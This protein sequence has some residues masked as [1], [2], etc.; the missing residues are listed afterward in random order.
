M[1]IPFMN[2]DQ[3]NDLIRDEV[4]ESV[5]TIFDSKNYVLGSNVSKF[6]TNYSK[7]NKTKYS[8]GVGSGLDALMISLK[9]LNISKGD[10]VII[11]SN[12]YIASWLS[13]SNVG[14]TIIPVEPDSETFNI[15]A[16][17]IENMIT[18]KT[19]LIMPVHLFGQS[20]NMDKIMSISKKYN[21]Y[22]VEDNA[23]GHL[24]KYDSKNT[25]TFGNINAT[26]FYPTKNLGAIGEAGCITTDNQNLKDFVVSYRNYGS[27]EKYINEIIGTNSRLDEIQAGILNVK[28]RYIQKWNNDR[29]IIASKYNSF[30]STCQ[31]I[32]LPKKLNKCDHVYHLYVIQTQKRDELQR[33]LSKNGIGTSIHYPIP[34]HLQKAYSGLKFKK[35]DFPIAEILAK[36]SLSLPIYPGLSDS[37]IQYICDTITKFF[38]N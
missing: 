27:K 13:I 12:A 21:L 16:D 2:F 37:E 11:A 23:Q 32:K 10:E 25:G 38:K 19:K 6:E 18:S 3:Q 36:T 7:I 14:A 30:L 26:S 8:V 4:L 1:K 9:A 29:K 17:K 34:P 35:G 28:L 31:Y 15:D 33:Y 24:A 20:C 5:K 22:V